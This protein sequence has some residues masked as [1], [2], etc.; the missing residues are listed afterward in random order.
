MSYPTDLSQRPTYIVGVA[1][2]ALGLVEDQ[3]EHSMVALAAIEALGEAGLK[4]RDVDGLF[5]NY[6]GEESSVQLGEYLG[7]EPRFADSSDLGGASFEAYIHHAMLAIAQGRCDVALIAFASRQRSKRGRQM[8][9]PVTE[10]SLSL[11]FEQPYALPI[12]IG[13]VALMASRHIKLY[14]TTLDQVAEVVLAARKWAQLNPK[15]WRREPLSLDEVR[16][17]PMVSTPVRKLDCC[18]I[19]D[20]GGVVIVTNR[21]RARDAVKAPVRVLGAGESHTVWN[22][23]QCRELTETAA[24]VSGREAFGMAG[25]RHEDIDFIE[26]YDAVSW[27]VLVALEDLGFC[28]KGEGG[29][30]ISGGRLAPGGALPAM[31]SGGGLSYNHPGAL[32]VLLLV[33]AVRQLRNEA[34]PRQVPN[35]RIGVVHGIGGQMSV[36]STVV[37]GNE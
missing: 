23:S 28:K 20:G 2:T 19:T 5:V 1:E 27:N 12:P 7:I 25:V 18:L 36:A 10:P 13:L 3:N 26:P 29:D 35:A 21:A 31:T 34:G 6:L 4:L 16:S 22:V 33:E 9:R 17:S 24:V 32:G 8:H 11:Q 14:G 37:L 15:A 30:F